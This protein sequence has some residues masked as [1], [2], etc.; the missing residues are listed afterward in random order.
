MAV[1]TTSRRRFALPTIGMAALVALVAATGCGSA[2]SSSTASTAKP[3]TGAAAA[4]KP[5]S[6]PALF[7]DCKAAS[8]NPEGCQG[9][10]IKG[11]YTAF[12]ASD[13]KNKWNLCVVAPD[14]H[15]SYWL[16]GNYGVIKEAQRLGVALSF[17]EA[18]GYTNLTKQISQMEDC[19][20]SGA[21]AI[22]AGAISYDGLDAQVNELAGNG[23][24]V[25][26]LVNGI[27]T[28]KV[29]AH[30][31]SSFKQLGDAVGKH[32]AEVGE[33]IQVALLPG[34]AGA[35]WAEDTVTGI[36]DAIKGS[37]VDI[38]ATKYADTGKDNQLQ[39]VE[40]VLNAY[41]DLDY[42]VGAAPT[43]D[44]AVGALKERDLI[45]KVKLVGTYMAPENYP[46]LE[47]GAQECAA[48]D[49]PVDQA[50]MSVDQAVRILEKQPLSGNYG[51]AAPDIQMVC[52]PG[53]DDD[54]L[55]SFEYDSTFAPKDYQPATSTD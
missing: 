9:E 44:V 46:H 4:E 30:A 17:H 55:K 41:P 53:S 40:D 8:T 35:G 43:M 33:P 14:L 34:P 23:I 10:F 11:T 13:V 5:W 37:Q 39:L 20:A 3:A 19:A 32:L 29:A 28:P 7:V 24:P 38:V 36:K 49:K 47:S 12:P 18:G 50:R 15:D 16:A 45:G 48:T 54:N 21:D 51:R 31:A 27:K 1:S 26:D 6:E 2:D 25:I 52:G 22:I 42:I